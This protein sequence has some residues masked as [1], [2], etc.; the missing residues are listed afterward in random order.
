[1]SADPQKIQSALGR[2]IREPELRARVATD[3]DATL[4]E[5]GLDEASRTAMLASGAERLLAYHSMVHSRLFR[6]IK[7]FMG[8]A[9]ERLGDARLHADVHAWTRDQGS[10]SPYL[11]EVPT[12]F[13][14][15]VRPRWEADEELP[16]WLC[17]LAQ[18]QISIRELRNDPRELGP[19]NEVKIDLERPI[20]CNA[21]AR[22]VRYH[23]SVHEL[24]RELGAAEPKLYAEPQSVVAYRDRD[25]RPRFVDIGP[26]AAHLLARLLAGATL[27]EALFGACEAMGE[28]LSDEILA[29]TALTLADLVD[30]HVLLGGG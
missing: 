20:A 26:R 25:D 17:E 18:H 10:R 12:E 4:A 19:Q 5:L 7:T 9:A 3:A 30:R 8:G 14:A 16:P 1:M 27:R 11:R 28:A 13:F 2:V 29:T 24:P 23:W 22:I 21:T 15:W 6:T